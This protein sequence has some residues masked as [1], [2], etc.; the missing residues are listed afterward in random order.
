ML[1]DSGVCEIH[2][3]CGKQDVITSCYQ[4]AS[5]V[6]MARQEPLIQARNTSEIQSREAGVK[7]QGEYKKL[8]KSD[9]EQIGIGYYMLCEL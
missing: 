6:R 4:M 1:I 5:V 9:F 3:T 8:S 7:C 2:D